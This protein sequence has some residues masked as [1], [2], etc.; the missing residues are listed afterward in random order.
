MPLPHGT[1]FLATISVSPNAYIWRPILLQ[2]VY[3]YFAGRRNV[4]VEDFCDE[5]ALGRGLR[6]VRWHH[7][8]QPEEATLKRSSRGPF[9]LS[10][11]GFHA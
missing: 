4:R 6:E 1:L 10:L 7:Q 2:N 9:K 3:A 11:Q 5:K 8:P